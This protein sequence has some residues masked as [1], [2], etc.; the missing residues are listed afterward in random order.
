VLFDPD[1]SWTIRGEDSPSAQGYT[2]FEGMEVTGKVCTTYLR[3]EA[4]YDNGAFPGTPRGQYIP[5]KV[6]R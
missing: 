2:P 6:R 3:G 4:V 1:A 5:R